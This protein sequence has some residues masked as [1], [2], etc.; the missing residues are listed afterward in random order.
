MF[1]L[2]CLLPGI[3]FNS[4]AP[5]DF[6]AFCLNIIIVFRFDVLRVIGSIVCGYVCDLEVFAGFIVLMIDCLRGV[7][8]TDSFVL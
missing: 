7:F 5:F 2:V 3:S 1:T 6:Y 4:S 8:G